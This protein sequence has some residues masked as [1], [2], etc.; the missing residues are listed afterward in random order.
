MARPSP[1]STQYD[2][3][4]SYM[5]GVQVKITNKY[6]SPPNLVFPEEY[7]VKPPDPSR[8]T[9]NFNLEKNVLVK[10]KAWRKARASYVEARKAKIEEKLMKATE[11]S[12]PSSSSTNLS[13][14]SVTATSSE[15]PLFSPQIMSLPD[16]NHFF[17]MKTNGLDY[18]DFDTD[19]SSPFD[20]MELKTINDMEALAEVLQPVTLSWKPSSNLEAAMKDLTVEQ[21]NEDL[22]E[23][24]ATFKNNSE[25]DNISNPLTNPKYHEISLIM[26]ELQKELDRPNIN[27]VESECNLESA[28]TSKNES[29]EKSI[30]GKDV[31]RLISALSVDEKKLVKYFSDMGFSLR[32]VVHA[33]GELSGEESKKILEYLLAIQSLEDLG[34]SEEAA[35]KALA[36]TQHDQQKAKEYHKN[37]RILQDLGFPEDKASAALLK[38]NMDRDS[39]LDLLIS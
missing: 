23:T 16:K 28:S 20:N 1:N 29:S 13:Q 26:Q 38:S 32:R 19:T 14:T 15:S 5:D 4:A 6:Q 24:N 11:K 3:I 30:D 35:I 34:I 7:Y 31:S 10:M 9:Y 2:S 36:L 33:I 18:S 37:L 22:K 17:P 25:S 8:Y 21:N 39:A 27:N 12:S